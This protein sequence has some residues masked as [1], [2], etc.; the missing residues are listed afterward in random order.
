V[1]DTHYITRL[2]LMCPYWSIY[3]SLYQGDKFSILRVFVYQKHCFFAKIILL[4]FRS[5]E[6]AG[7]PK[8]AQNSIFGI[9]DWLTQWLFTLIT[10]SS[11]IWTTINSNKNYGIEPL[12][13]V[14]K[15][16]PWNILSHWGQ[17]FTWHTKHCW[18]QLQ[19]CFKLLVK[20][21]LSSSAT[22]FIKW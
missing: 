22:L 20:C 18:I 14:D 6:M 21:H 4:N 7:H 5:A 17:R 16:E 1:S 15:S 3:L 8:F 13:N 9:C 19:F 10:S 12:V 2:Y 11:S